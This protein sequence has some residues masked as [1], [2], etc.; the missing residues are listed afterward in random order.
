MGGIQ[1]EGFRKK[2]ER[3]KVKEIKRDL[4]TEEELCAPIHCLSQSAKPPDFSFW[5]F[6]SVGL[7]AGLRLSL[8]VFAPQSHGALSGSLAPSCHTL[9]ESA[10][11]GSLSPSWRVD[12]TGARGARVKPL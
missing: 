5:L 2:R 9:T 6:R 4:L 1:S 8:A 7:L 10:P 3:L 12:Y 11:P